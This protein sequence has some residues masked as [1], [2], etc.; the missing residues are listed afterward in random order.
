VAVHSR[1]RHWSELTVVVFP[2]NPEPWRQLRAD[3]FDITRDRADALN[4]GFGVL[5]FVPIVDLGYS[6]EATP[7]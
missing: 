5:D 6:S 1:H 4:L 7:Q 2:R 3:T